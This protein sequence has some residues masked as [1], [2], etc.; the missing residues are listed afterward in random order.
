MYKYWS[1]LPILFFAIAVNEEPTFVESVWRRYRT[2]LYFSL[3]ASRHLL[4]PAH[5]CLCCHMTENPLDL[6]DGKQ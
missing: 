1:K 3:S 5:W 4:S 6:A 2:D